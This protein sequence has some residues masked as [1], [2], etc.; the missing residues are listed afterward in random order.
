MAGIAVAVA[1]VVAGVWC[2]RLR[3]PVAESATEATVAIRITRHDANGVPGKPSFVRTPERVRGIV[4]ALGV[5]MHP[6]RTCPADYASAELGLLLSGRDVY[7]RRNVY[8]WGLFAEDGVP[9]VVVVTSSGCRG[10]APTDS[11]TLR[12]ELG[13]ELPDA[14]AGGV[15][16]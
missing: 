2:G 8:V 4:K 11:A 1:L 5:D 7:A 15:M 10:G 12:R 16:R 14:D 9:D 13:R 3:P 6:A